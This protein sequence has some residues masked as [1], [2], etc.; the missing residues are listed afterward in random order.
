MTGRENAVN[1]AKTLE[2]EV[3][4]VT[5][6]DPDERLTTGA[7]VGVGLRD[8][9]T[10]GVFVGVE[11]GVGV[12]VVMLGVELG[13]AVTVGEEGVLV[14]VGLALGLAVEVGD[15]APP[16]MVIVGMSGCESLWLLSESHANS[17]TGAYVPA[18]DVPVI[19]REPVQWKVVGFPVV[20]QSTWRYWVPPSRFHKAWAA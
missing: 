20:L 6:L 14:A 9:L 13:L 19:G 12:T 4:Q 5:R 7:V 1:P 17:H 18:T 11:R 2:S 16:L 15:A 8:G 10:V 3:G